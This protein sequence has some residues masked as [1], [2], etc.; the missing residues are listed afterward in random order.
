MSVRTFTFLTS[1]LATAGMMFGTA[2]VQAN[3]MSQLGTWGMPAGHGAGVSNL[4]C[5]GVPGI[6][7]VNIRQMN[8]PRTLGMS[9][10]RPN[11]N[12]AEQ[13]RQFH[14]MAATSRAIWAST[15]R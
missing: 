13:F 15:S 9:I 6:G 4:T 3:G 8:L 14:D 2:A 5:D 1:A 12:G 7:Q 10:F 11:V